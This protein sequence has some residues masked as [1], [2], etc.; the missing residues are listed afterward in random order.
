LLVDLQPALPD[1]ISDEL[2]FPDKPETE[3]FFIAAV[4]SDLPNLFTEL[5]FKVLTINQN[6]HC[7][8]FQAGK[9]T[10]KFNYFQRHSSFK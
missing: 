9:D 5:I 10:E 8:N 4:A 6:K 1:F 2:L 7:S 3:G